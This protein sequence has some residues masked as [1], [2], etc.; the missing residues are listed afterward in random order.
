MIG[1]RVSKGENGLGRV[2]MGN[3]LNPPPIPYYPFLSPAVPYNKK[4]QR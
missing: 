3:E 1:L 2:R 4:K